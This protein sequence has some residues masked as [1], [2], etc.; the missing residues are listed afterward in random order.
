MRDRRNSRSVLASGTGSAALQPRKR[1][2][3]RETA[4]VEALIFELLVA[5]AVKFSQHQ[6]F[7]F[8]DGMISWASAGSERFVM[9]VGF[10]FRQ[11]NLPVDDLVQPAEEIPHLIQFSPAKYFIK[12]S[13]LA[14][15]NVLTHS[16]SAY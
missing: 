4:P 16:K 14:G 6:H 12:P 13:L 15:L 10:E 2:K 1:E 11:K 5:E 3:A 9:E 8:E 7:E